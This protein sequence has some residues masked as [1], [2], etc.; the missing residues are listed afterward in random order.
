M[1]QAASAASTPAEKYPWEEMALEILQGQ[2]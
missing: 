1:V 2:Q